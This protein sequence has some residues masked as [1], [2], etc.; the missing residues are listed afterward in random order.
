MT[1]ISERFG[2]LAAGFTS[3]VDSVPDDRWDSPSPCQDWT[4]KGIVRHMCENASLFFGF[5]GDEV[6]PGPSP[7]DDPPGA[8]ANAR[9]ALQQ[10]LDD[11]AVAGKEYE[12][13]FGTSTFEKAV[14]QFLGIDLVVH[15]W[16][17]ARAAGLDDRLDPDAVHEVFEAVKPMDGPMRAS[18]TFGPKLDPPDGADEQTR[19]LAF[20]G[21]QV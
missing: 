13:S 6:P 15:N 3:T 20:L 4:A 8:W 9:D 2:R 17:L 12:G 21:R 11:P 14:D 7:D 18:G 19:L 16:D 5:I 10:G 1:A